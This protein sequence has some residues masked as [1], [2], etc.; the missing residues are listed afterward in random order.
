MFR[1]V[2]ANGICFL[3]FALTVFGDSSRVL[4]DANLPASFTTTQEHGGDR[5]HDR[6]NIAAINSQQPKGRSPI[7][8]EPFGLDTSRVVTGELAEKWSDVQADIRAD[9]KILASCRETTAPCPV[10]A[11]TFL[12]IVTD[13]RLH[14][15]RARIG[16]INRAINL[17][18]RPMSGVPWVSPL[19]TLTSGLGDCK[20]YAL[21]KYVALRA[22][23][24]SEDDVRLLIVR[25]LAVGEDHAVVAVR[26]GSSWIILDNRW[27]TL[28]EDIEMRSV[29]PLFVMDQEGVK[30]FAMPEVRRASA[31]RKAVESAIPSDKSRR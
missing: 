9:D 24:I 16:V 1:H 4:A 19:A 29:I 13:G 7:P 15:G 17:A 18:I 12:A 6:V 21:A 10:A 28:V 11:R 14:V 25:N 5:T 22:A 26:L 2:A 27:L 30:Q 3:V 20:N 23:G 31:S 8:M